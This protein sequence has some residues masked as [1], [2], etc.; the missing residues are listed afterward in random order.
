MSVEVR[1]PSGVPVQVGPEVGDRSDCRGG[2]AGTAGGEKATEPGCPLAHSGDRFPVTGCL[3]A[4][5]KNA[6]ARSDE[7]LLL[8]PSR[9]CGCDNQMFHTHNIHDPCLHHD[10]RVA[11]H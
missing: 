9:G 10:L 8:A 4:P 3:A 7:T 5:T 1:G 6:A 2:P 11:L